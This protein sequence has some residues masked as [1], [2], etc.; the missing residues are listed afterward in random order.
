MV[1]AIP[2]FM[3]LRI[4][5]TAQ[6]FTLAPCC[7]QR[8]TPLTTVSFRICLFSLSILHSPTSKTIYF[9]LY[10]QFSSLNSLSS[11]FFTSQKTLQ[12]KSGSN[13]IGTSLPPLQSSFRSH[14]GLQ[15]SLRKIRVLLRCLA[16]LL[17][18]HLM[19]ATDCLNWFGMLH[20]EGATWSPTAV[21][22]WG[23]QGIILLCRQRISTNA[24]HH[25]AA[26]FSAFLC[27]LLK[28]SSRTS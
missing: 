15:N 5:V 2:T 17:L 22:N 26:D 13:I 23:P 9:P 12:Q 14:F 7:P 10:P 8:L 3:R 16:I 1:H 25:R 21:R 6:I 28:K 11:G 19:I 27:C 20:G 24:T 18:W 4:Q